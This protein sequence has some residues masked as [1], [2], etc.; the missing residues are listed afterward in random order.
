MP[1]LILLDVM[2]PRMNGLDTLMKLKCNSKTLHIPVIMLSGAGGKEVLNK[3][4]VNGAC[5]FIKK[6]FNGEML[7]EVIKK[8]L[9]A[10]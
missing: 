9:S 1:D 8:N 2:M 7:M 6:P 4:L 10:G 3:A 5:D